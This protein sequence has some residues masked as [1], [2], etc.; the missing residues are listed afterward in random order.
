MAILASELGKALIEA[1]GLPKHTLAFTLSCRAGAAVRVEC[2]YLPQNSDR[3]ASALMEYDLVPSFKPAP[4]EAPPAYHFD[5][6]YRHRIN[7]AH[8]KYME[9]TSYRLPCDWATFPPEAIEAYLNGPG[10]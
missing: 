2:E 10:V 7:V 1:L 6:W 9:R 8:A 5:D 3:L 4:V